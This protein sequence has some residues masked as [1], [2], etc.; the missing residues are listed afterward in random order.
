VRERESLYLSH[1]M[2]SINEFLPDVHS[3]RNVT[4]CIGLCRYSLPTKVCY[5]SLSNYGQQPAAEETAVFSGII[6]NV[7]VFMHSCAKSVRL[8]IEESVRT[9]D[10]SSLFRISCILITTT[11]NNFRSNNVLDYRNKIKRKL[12]K[13]YYN[14]NK[15]DT[16]F[17]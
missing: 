10:I 8:Q 2:Q 15:N 6:R 12:R 13:N 14:E 7:V 17:D 16:I 3:L 5:R 9:P 4:Q 11:T 1:V